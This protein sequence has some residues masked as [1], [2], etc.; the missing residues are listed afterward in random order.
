MIKTIS[1]FLFIPIFFVTSK[2]FAEKKPQDYFQCKE[3]HKLLYLK[4]KKPI[5]VVNAFCKKGKT[6]KMRKMKKAH[7]VAI[8]QKKRHFSCPSY[9]TCQK[10][11]IYDKTVAPTP[12]PQTHDEQRGIR[13]GG[14]K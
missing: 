14:R 2:V 3:N 1:L 9:F 5:C 11:N 10:N 12:L 8:K 4:Q 7:C 6:K 13:G